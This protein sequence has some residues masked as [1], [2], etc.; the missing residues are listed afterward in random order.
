MKR[1]ETRQRIGVSSSTSPAC[2]AMMTSSK[3][4]KTLPAPLAFGLALMR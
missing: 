3:L 1:P 2:S 4:P